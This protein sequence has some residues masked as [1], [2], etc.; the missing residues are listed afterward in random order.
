[1]ENFGSK[2]AE[3]GPRWLCRNSPGCFVAQSC[4]ALENY[5]LIEMQADVIV[6]QGFVT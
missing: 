6:H 4:K 5:V 2:V 1:M 3:S